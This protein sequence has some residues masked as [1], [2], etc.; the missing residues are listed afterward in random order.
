MKPS[1]LNAWR[2][3][4]A[5]GT[6]WLQAMFAK[7]FPSTPNLK[8]TCWQIHRHDTGM[9]SVDFSLPAECSAGGA[10]YNSSGWNGTALGDR[11]Y[12][13]DDGQ[14]RLAAF[15]N[16]L[17]DMSHRRLVTP[18]LTA[19]ADGKQL[20]VKKSKGKKEVLAT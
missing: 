18:D 9:V 7:I 19:T 11:Y 6:D 15:M 20:F 14:A 8:K 4:Q 2:N 5:F 10:T 12:Y 16:F 13:P 1:H 3:I 17:I